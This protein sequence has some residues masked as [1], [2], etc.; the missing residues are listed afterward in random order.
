MAAGRVSA[1]QR[2]LVLWS[3]AA[4]RGRATEGGG[5]NVGHTRVDLWDPQEARG[6]VCGIPHLAKNERDVGYGDRGGDGA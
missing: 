2:T 3:G 6:E 5:A 4:V 1:L